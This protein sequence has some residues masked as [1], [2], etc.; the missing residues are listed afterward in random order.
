MA[1]KP[2]MPIGA[3]LTAPCRSVRELA[4]RFAR[5]EAA[6]RRWRQHPGWPDKVPTKAPW[7]RRQMQAIVAFVDTLRPTN[8]PNGAVRKAIIQADC[9]LKAARAS[10][11]RFR[12]HRERGE[13]VKRGDVDKWRLAALYT[14]R[15]GLARLA[16]S[17][18]RELDVPADE[19]ERAA[20]VLEDRFAELCNRFADAAD[21]MH[22]KATDTDSDE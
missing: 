17:L 6:V 9:D 21:P 5:S 7:S 10:L 2:T 1:K 3:D 8:N 19:Q 15:T 22:R 20:S 11:M 4:R 13:Y 18:P 16:Q 12:E 14:F